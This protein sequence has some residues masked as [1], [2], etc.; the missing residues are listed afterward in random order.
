MAFRFKSRV[1]GD[2]VM[3]AHNAKPLLEL[4]GKAVDGPGILLCADMPA[5]LKTLDAA[6]AQD[7]AHFAQRVQT[8]KDAGEPLPEPDRIS[9]RMRTKPFVDLLRTSIQENAEV[10]WG[11]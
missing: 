2:V 11:V 5:A 10:V 7:E 8:A 6:I 1:T 4:L 3:L 9:L